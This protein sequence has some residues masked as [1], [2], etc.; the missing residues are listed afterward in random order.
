MLSK[1][2]DVKNPDTLKSLWQD[3]SYKTVGRMK[4]YLKG[5]LK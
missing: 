4:G 5:N 3:P 1:Y 2:L